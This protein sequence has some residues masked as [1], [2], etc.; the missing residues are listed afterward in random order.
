MVTRSRKAL[1]WALLVLSLTLSVNSVLEPLVEVVNTGP[2]I[3][4]VK[5]YSMYLDNT[6]NVPATSFAAPDKKAVYVQIKVQDDNGFS[7]VSL[8]GNVKIKIVLWNGTGE[9]DYPRFGSSYVDASFESGSGIEATYRYAY[10]M[11]NSDETRMGNEVLPLFYRVKVLVSDGEANASSNVSSNNADY[12]YQCYI[13]P[14]PPLQV[15]FDVSID[16]PSN[17]KTIPPGDSFYAVVAITKMSP[18]GLDDIQIDYGIID[19]LNRTVDH[20]SEMVAINTTI[21]RVPVLYLTNSSMPGRY[22]FRVT[23]SYMGTQAWSEAF[24]DVILPAT[25]TTY[26]TPTTTRGVSNV[27]TTTQSS[28]TSGG[29]GGHTDPEE[30]AVTQTTTVAT[31]LPVEPSPEVSFYDYPPVVQAFSGDSKPI[32]IIVENTGNVLLNDV[33]VFLGG[34]LNVEKVIPASVDLLEPG[35]RAVFIIDARIP[36]NLNPADYN[37]VVKIISQDAVDERSMKFVVLPRPAETAK[38]LNMEADDIN[39]L[40]DDVW[41]EAIKTGMREDDVRLSEIFEL[42]SSSKDK[43]NRAREDISGRRYID[44]KETMDSA[45]TDIENSV[46]KLAGIKSE[47]SSEPNV[48]F[49]PV[50][51]STP[52]SPTWIA[53]VIIACL[54]IIL[55]GY[56][57]FMKKRKGRR[58][59]ELYDLRMTKDLIFGHMNARKGHKTSIA[60]SSDSGDKRGDNKETLKTIKEKTK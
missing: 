35:A 58:L 18:E 19:P 5:T 2:Q 59:E 53:G 23:V 49:V 46:L 15:L 36:D 22:I 55:V 32:L 29:G 12:A 41:S 28:S 47:K 13:P 16:I 6:N 38:T 8:R 48:V 3:V 33:T 4:S 17:K 37:T 57:L 27:T 51:A 31:T 34:A 25:T 39:K 24:F 10:M 52:L 50:E 11:D 20:F 30:P 14:R 44:G 40:A 43:I 60:G 45:K 21:Y 26:S 7:D 42:L 54:A 1:A 56:D 9:T